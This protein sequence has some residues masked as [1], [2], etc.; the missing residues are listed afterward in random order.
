MQTTVIYTADWIPSITGHNVIPPILINYAIYCITGLLMALGS[1]LVTFGALETSLKFGDFSWPFW[2]TTDLAPRLVEAKCV[3]PWAPFQQPNSW[4]SDST[5]KIH[6]ETYRNKGI[7]KN[8]D[9]NYE[10]TK[11]QG[12]NMISSKQR[13]QDKGPRESFAAWWPLFE[14]PAD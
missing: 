7:R 14:G 8:Q 2:V 3:G 5:C 10:N 13:S 9:A 11:N 4:S 12:C 1:I 6:F